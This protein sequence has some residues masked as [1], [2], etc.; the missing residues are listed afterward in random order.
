MCTVMDNHQPCIGFVS[1]PRFVE[2][3]IIKVHFLMLKLIVH[4]NNQGGIICG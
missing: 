4:P 1:S 3:F 2:S